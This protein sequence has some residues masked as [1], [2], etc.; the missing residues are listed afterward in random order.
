MSINRG[1]Q[2]EGIIESAF[3]SVPNTTIVRLHDQTTGFK[4]SVNPC[5][6][7]VF[8]RPYMY[9]IECK[10]V[11]GNTFPLSNITDNQWNKLLEMSKTPGVISGVICWWVDRDE[12]LFIPAITLKNVRDRNGKSIRFDAYTTTDIC[13]RIHGTKKRVFFEYDMERFMKEAEDWY[14][15]QQ[16]IDYTGASRKRLPQH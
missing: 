10:S 3:K 5:D 8:H 11:H 2:F 1:K 12:T 16:S 15:R 7:I 13:G 4:G 6:F 14:D 9:A